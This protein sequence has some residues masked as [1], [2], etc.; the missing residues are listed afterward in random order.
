M[1]SSL[2]L[3]IPSRISLAAST[4]CLL[5]GGEKS[6]LERKRTSSMMP[7]TYPRLCCWARSA[8]AAFVPGGGMNIPR[9]RRTLGSVS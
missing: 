1:T 4:L 2:C 7:K 3:L 9:S 5:A 6:W 8:A